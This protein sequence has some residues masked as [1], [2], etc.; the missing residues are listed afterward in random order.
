MAPGV[1]ILKELSPCLD[2]VLYLHVVV[3]RPIFECLKLKLENCLGTNYN[4]SIRCIEGFEL[5]VQQFLSHIT[6]NNFEIIGDKIW[7]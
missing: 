4:L 6:D 3:S 1:I 5:S 2:P 7:S